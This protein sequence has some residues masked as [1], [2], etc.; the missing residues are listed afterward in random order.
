MFLTMTEGFKVISKEAIK[1]NRAKS[2][3]EMTCSPGNTTFLKIKVP[4]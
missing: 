3:N 2:S 4:K 1:C